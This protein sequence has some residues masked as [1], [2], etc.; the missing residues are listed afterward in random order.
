MYICIFYFIMS[1]VFFPVKPQQPTDRFLLKEKIL[2]VACP[3]F[4]MFFT[5]MFLAGSCCY[6]TFN[7]WQRS[8]L[9]HHRHTH[10]RGERNGKGEPR[11]ALWKHTATVKSRVLKNFN[12]TCT[13]IDVVK[14]N[15]NVFSFLYL[16]IMSRHVLSVKEI[17][18]KIL[19]LQQRCS[20]TLVSIKILGHSYR[21]L[22]LKINY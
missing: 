20:F 17:C 19:Y 7:K 10:G 15:W 11:S 8:Q 21:P 1:G 9:C 3:C 2:Y 6:C 16:S 18:Q 12:V 14:Y 22:I 4:F 13:D 5:K